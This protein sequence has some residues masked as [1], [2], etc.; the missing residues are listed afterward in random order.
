M[1]EIKV[2]DT[3]TGRQDDVQT[4]GYLLIYI[5]DENIEFHG[6]MSIKSLAPILTRFVLEKMTK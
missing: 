6:K 1:I 2:N 3:E 5:K 4:Q